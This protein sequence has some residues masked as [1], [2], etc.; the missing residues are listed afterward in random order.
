MASLPPRAG[1]GPLACGNNGGPPGIALRD[2]SNFADC[3]PEADGLHEIYF[4]YD[5]EAEYVGRARGEFVPF[6]LL[7]TAEAYFPV[8][9]S[10]LI[11]DQGVVR[12]LRLVT[13]PRPDQ[14]T[15]SDLFALRPRIEHAQFADYM[16]RRLGIS[17]DE[18]LDLPPAPGET[19]V[20]GM[21]T[22]RNCAASSE[23]GRLSYVIEQR[24]LRK[25]GQYD[26]DPETGRASM[27]A[28]ESTARLEIRWLGEP[29]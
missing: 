25:P 19:A 29:R 17:P 18:C 5:D 27:D 23:D 7:G 20:I 8:I 11:D 1:F 9:A 21:L 15:G 28:F 3:R 14:R 2:W 4:E 24:F 6:E 26:V 12:G 10:I 16:I 13:D 22:K